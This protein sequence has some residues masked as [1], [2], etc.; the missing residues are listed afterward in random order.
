MSAIDAALSTIDRV[1]SE[2]DLAPE[3]PSD[4]LELDSLTEPVVLPDG[5]RIYPPRLHGEPIDELACALIDTDSP[6][7]STFL[8]LIGPPGSGKSQI[9]RAVA[10]RLWQARGRDGRGPSRRPVLRVRRDHRRPVQRRVP[11]PPRVRPRRRRRRHR[12]ARR[13]RVRAGDAR[14]LGGDDR[15]GQH[16]PRRRPAQ[17]QLVPRRPPVAL[18]AGDRRD[19]DRAAR[20]RVPARLQPRPGRAPTDIPDAWHSRFPATLEVTSN[21]PALAELGAPRPLVTEAMALDRQRIAGEDGLT[22]TPQFRD[23]E[24]LTRMIDRVGERAALA[25]FVSNLSEQVQ[26]GKVQDAEAAA[27]CRMLDQAGYAHLKVSATRRLPSL[28]GY[29]RAVTS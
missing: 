19:R 10:Y 13:L 16:D 26:A 22:W 2:G 20:V 8:R 28:H 7:E 11:V 15:R 29:P 14:G 23:I 12:P 5:K 3:R 1:A 6:A 21:W 9:A 27:V 18:P 24:A 17:H 25:L 4:L